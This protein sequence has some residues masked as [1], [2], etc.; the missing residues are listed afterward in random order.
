MS[1]AQPDSILISS[2][3]LRVS[4]LEARL[5]ELERRTP[6][7]PLPPYT[8]RPLP[9]TVPWPHGPHEPPF[10]KGGVVYCNCPMNTACMSTACPRAPK[11]TCGGSNA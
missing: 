6:S 3:L 5:A 7:S 8:Y 10:G 1:E 9:D 11:V 2:L 4:A